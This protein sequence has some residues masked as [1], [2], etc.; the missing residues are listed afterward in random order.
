M[1]ES[2]SCTA[3]KPL[4]SLA[5]TGL[6][7]WSVCT[8]AGVS[9]PIS[10][11]TVGTSAELRTPSAAGSPLFCAPA[12]HAQAAHTH[13]HDPHWREFLTS[14]LLLTTT[15]DEQA[16]TTIHEFVSEAVNSGAMIPTPLP[17]T[18]QRGSRQICHASDSKLAGFDR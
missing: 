18:V 3:R 11:P 17:V 4:P 14:H 12:L 8:K 15:F 6:C 5:S 7:P 1:R 9:V 13:T 2:T 16:T 10:G